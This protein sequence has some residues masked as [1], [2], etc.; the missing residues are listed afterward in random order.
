MLRATKGPLVLA[1]LVVVIAACDDDGSG[2]GRPIDPATAPRASIDRF[3]DAAGM[4]YRR[5]ATASLPGAN[6]AI[7]FDQAPFITQGL[8]PNGQPVRYYNFDVM[9]NAPAPIYV[10]FREGETQPVAGQL[11]IVDVIPGEAG[12]NDFWQVTRVSVPRNYVANTVTSR[13]Q[14]MAQR[15][16]METTTTL[17][18]CPIVP[19]GST[20]REGGGAAGATQGWYK[21][22]VVFYFNFGEAPLAATTGGRVPTS[23]IF[24]TFNINPDR[25]NGGP[26]SGFRTQGAS[27]QTHNVIATLP[28]Q[29][30]Y[31]PLWEVFAYDNAAFGMV[32]D[33]ATAQAARNFGRAALVNCP[34][35]F[36]GTAPANPTTV[37]KASIDRFGPSAGLF[38]RTASN[39]MP[40]AGAAIDMDRAP[41]IT[42]GLGPAGQRVRYYNFD[43]QPRRPAPIYVLFHQSG[44]PVAG[45]LNIV[46]VIPGQTGYNDFWRVVRVTVPDGYIANSAVTLQQL[47]Q[48]AY[49]M[50][51]TNT[52]VNCPI[53]P[54]GSR[55][56]LGGGAAGL[57]RG[58]FRGQ[59]VFYFNFGEA[60]ITATA[61]GDVPISPIYVTFNINPGMPNGGPGS[62]FRT[63]PGTVQT[64]NVIATIP[65]QSGYSPLW[66]VF[67]YDNADFAA[68][69]NLATAQAARSFG[70]AA[71]VNCPVVFVQ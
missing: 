20:A 33:L 10:L 9:T 65:G 16:R 8:G 68:V 3:S 36:V 52:I 38:V 25:P 63:E 49:P 55:A 4:L 24:V 42:N 14:I 46:D 7:N 27:T 26:P 41:F 5:S 6:R 45:Q 57:V 44:Q 2:P 23:P 18:N 71:L 37:Q 11:N 70:S 39:G 62:G 48:A 59:V 19:E 66:E 51:M 60:P 22:Q 12:Y 29:P 61:T 64:H 13:A 40:A 28:G 54:D 58:W 56:T 50:Q 67:P 21:G 31:S 43:V 47:Q 34:V 1:G 15:Y 32:L 30:G 35:V 53:V 17:V 69:T